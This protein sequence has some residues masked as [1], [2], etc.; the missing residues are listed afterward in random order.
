MLPRY[1]A[2]GQAAKR[3][4]R[5][6]YFY[7]HYTE[8]TTGLKDKSGG[9]SRKERKIMNDEIMKIAG[10]STIIKRI[11]QHLINIVVFNSDHATE[12]N[13]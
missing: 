7:S 13:V 6:G 1:A 4:V 8:C 12:L 10:E 2:W 3:R 11:D 9:A 5:I